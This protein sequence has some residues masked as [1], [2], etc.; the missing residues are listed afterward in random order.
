M[1]NII[2]AQVLLLDNKIE[3]WKICQSKKHSPYDF[4]AFWKME[5][6]KDYTMETVIF[7][8]EKTNV[9]EGWDFNTYVYEVLAPQWINQWEYADDYK[10]G[11][12]TIKTM[13]EVIAERKQ[14]SEIFGE[15]YKI[16]SC[17]GRN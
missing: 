17:L 14:L 15:R 13:D 6:I 7:E 9:E 16:V 4:K 3:S 12:A 5:R 2:Y 8:K 10:G 11:E 1:E